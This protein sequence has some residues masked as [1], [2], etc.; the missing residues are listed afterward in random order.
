MNSV[1]VEHSPKRNNRYNRENNDKTPPRSST[2]ET[3]GYGTTPPHHTKNISTIIP[4]KS[5]FSPG[6]TDGTFSASSP[7]ISKSMGYTGTARYNNNNTLLLSGHSS[8]T[9]S[10]FPPIVSTTNPRSSG[11]SSSSSSTSY[12]G[13]G[14]Y[15]SGNSSS[16]GNNRVFAHLQT[17]S[18]S[19]MENQNTPFS[20]NEP[21]PRL[22]L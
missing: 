3:E 1:P 6:S 19:T 18:V 2:V 21:I 8:V 22:Y 5:A 13:S 17:P 12:G 14:I 9:N 10:P 11:T 20:T 15:N 16:N 4:T 7:L